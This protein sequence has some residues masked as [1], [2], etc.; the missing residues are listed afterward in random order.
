MP[1]ARFQ[2]YN[3]AGGFCWVLLCVWSGYLFGNIPLVKNNFGLV[4]IGIAVISV[5][6]M[7]I[8]LFRRPATAS[9]QPRG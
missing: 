8:A 3:I 7:V 6:P 4:T 1:Y 5:L 9:G 2:G